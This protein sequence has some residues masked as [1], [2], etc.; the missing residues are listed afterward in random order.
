MSKYAKFLRVIYDDENIIHSS[1]VSLTTNPIDKFFYDFQKKYAVI[2][3]TYT[4]EKYRGK[5]YYKK[6]LQLQIKNIIA[7]FEI[8][9]IFMSTLKKEKND[10]I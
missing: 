6:A 3:S 4:H 1:G 5:Q 8:N 9:E 10:S 2:Y 7:K